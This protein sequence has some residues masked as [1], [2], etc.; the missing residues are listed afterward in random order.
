MNRPSEI[1]LAGGSSI[2][3]TLNFAVSLGV[4]ESPDVPQSAVGKI[5]QLVD[6]P[7]ANL[8]ELKPEIR[9]LLARAIDQFERNSRGLSG[10]QLG[11]SYG[12]LGLHYQAHDQQEAAA[13]CY[14]NAIVLDGENFQWSYLLAVHYEETGDPD[15]ATEYYILSLRLNPENTAGATRLGLLLVELNRLNMAEQIFDRILVLEQDNA[16][17]LAGLG[18]IAMERKDYAVAIDRFQRAL[19]IQ[20][21][22]N[23]L[24]YRIALG[25]RQLGEIDKAK[26]HLAE[27]GPRIPTIRDPL[28]AVMMAHAKGSKHFISEGKKAAEAGEFQRSA[29]LFN[30]AAAIDPEDISAYIDLGRVSISVGKLASA[31]R[32]FEKALSLD[33]DNALA[34]FYIGD[35]LER[36]G[37]DHDAV[38]HFRNSVAS[39]TEF[40][41]SRLRLANAL[42]RTRQY[43]DAADQF[44]LLSAQLRDN[45]EIRYR[46]GVALL[47]AGQC[48]QAEPLLLESQ[49]NSPQVPN[50]QLALARLYATCPASEE[51]RQ[52]SLKFAKHLYDSQPGLETAVT[53]AMS[54]AANGRF[55][56]ASVYQAKAIA[57]ARKAGV[58]EQRPELKQ[59]LERYLASQAA[60]RAWPE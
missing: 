42:M 50:I 25:Y 29:Q 51:K 55:Q 57:E 34:N 21:E 45:S 39:N 9:E 14:H 18:G 30:R 4:A 27:R 31:Q 60:I 44:G 24:H 33:P 41:E 40:T 22:A 2:V 32:S 56:D 53:L 35:V 46:H 13:A 1:L 59:N 26:A 43:N 20:P 58:V 7:H 11:L 17:A 38:K 12:R 48:S 3:I 54:M 49:Q 15:R 6:V 5:E 23:R 8:D 19:T 52:Q 16:A 47:A 37:A 36:Q 10:E 28:L